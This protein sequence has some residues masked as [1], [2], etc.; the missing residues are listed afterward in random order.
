MAVTRPGT[1]VTLRVESWEADWPVAG[2]FL[3]TE[4]GSC[5]R[6]EEVRP[7]RF[8]SASLGS[9]VCTRLERDAVRL[10]APGVFVW[11]F[12]ARG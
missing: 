9:F 6:I 10:G 2:D 1:R 8:G 5:Y 12:A 4:S 3:R 11:R 7:A